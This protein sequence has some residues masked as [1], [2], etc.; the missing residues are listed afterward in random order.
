M[1]PGEQSVD[2]ANALTDAEKP[3][4]QGSKAAN[5]GAY[6]DVSDRNLQ[7][8][9]TKQAK[10]PTAFLLS[11][12]IFAFA[13]IVSGLNQRRKPLAQSVDKVNTLPDAK[14]ACKT[15]KQGCK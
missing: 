8:M 7:P 10:M 4:I 13:G 11:V 15:R 3:A 9:L 12:G 14:K 2:K 1:T 6:T 5:D